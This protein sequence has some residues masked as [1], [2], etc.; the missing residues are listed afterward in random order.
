MRSGFGAAPP[1][2]ASCTETLPADRK[3]PGPPL[4]HLAGLF[5]DALADERLVSRKHGRLWT[6]VSPR[7]QPG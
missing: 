6:A 3:H 2:N 1:R 4:A 5:P 7:L